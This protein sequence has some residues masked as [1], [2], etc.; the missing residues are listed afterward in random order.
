MFSEETNDWK[1]YM[2]SAWRTTYGQ[3]VLSIEKK[4]HW[5]YIW[6]F[7]MNKSNTTINRRRSAFKY[8]DR[9]W[10]LALVATAILLV[11][12]LSTQDIVIQKNSYLRIWFATWQHD[13]SKQIA[14]KLIYVPWHIKWI[15]WPF[16]LWFPIQYPRD[17]SGILPI[18]TG[19]PTVM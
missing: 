11:W 1:N 12:Y 13:G 7:A 14:T 5:S 15:Q 9:F 3:T 18:T 8:F 17:D 6:S 4:L 19:S 10:R 16:L 2:L